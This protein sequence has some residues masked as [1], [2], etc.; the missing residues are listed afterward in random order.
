MHTKPFYLEILGQE[1]AD[2]RA[3]NSRYSLRAFARFLKIEPGVLSMIFAEK[4]IPSKQFAEKIP[5]LLSMT[6][7]A[8]H[9]FQRSIAEMR[10]QTKFGQLN[11]QFE[12]QHPLGKMTA[13]EV[14]PEEFEEIAPWYHYATLELTFVDGF[15]GTVEWIAKRLALKKLDVSRAIERLKARG[16]LTAQNGTLVKTDPM[17]A[18]AKKNQ[19]SAA[20]RARQKQCLEF[21]IQS[22]E[23]VPLEQRNHTAM[24]MAIDPEKLPEAKKMIQEFSR[25]L[26]SFL[27]TGKRKRVYELSVSLFPLDRE[28]TP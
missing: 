16:L 18:T 24:T 6:N 12:G 8:G 25:S 13:R 27:E 20:H 7:P 1:F 9:A 14:L 10:R 3:R 11:Q 4:R 23:N 5:R 26:C 2:R 15:V 22:L 21:S 17:V 28:P 19:T